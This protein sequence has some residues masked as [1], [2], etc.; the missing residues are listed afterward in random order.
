MSANRLERIMVIYSGFTLIELLIA[1][2]VIAIL[3]GIAYPSYQQHIIKSRRAEA[4]AVLLEAA[5]WMERFHTENNRY[6][7]SRPGDSVALPRILQRVP[8]DASKQ[9]YT[10]SLIEVTTTAFSLQAIPAGVQSQDPCGILL[11]AHT[12]A[13]GVKNTTGYTKEH[14]W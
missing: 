3:A 5:Q 6:D 11:L 7:L 9:Y 13:K 10:V 2:T 4:K 8:T 14:C 1:L 12:G